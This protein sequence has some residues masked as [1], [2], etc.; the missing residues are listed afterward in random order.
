MKEALEGEMRFF[1]SDA[2]AAV[3]SEPSDGA[4]DGQASF[5]ASQG[6]DHPGEL[7]NRFLNGQTEG[8]HN[9]N[10]A[11]HEARPTVNK[12]WNSYLDRRPPESRAG[13]SR[14]RTLGPR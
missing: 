13:A 4:F 6:V 3:V 14:V 10:S 9:A 12:S 8:K 2:K 1:P 11:P 5:V 7:G